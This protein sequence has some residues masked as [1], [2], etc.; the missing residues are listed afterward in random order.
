MLRPTALTSAN[1][2]ILGTRS[3]FS[4]HA[5]CPTAGCSV[6]CLAAVR[7]E[8]LIACTRCECSLC[9]ACAA[10]AT[11]WRSPTGQLLESLVTNTEPRFNFAFSPFDDDMRRMQQHSVVEPTLTAAWHEA[12]WKCCS[13]ADGIVVDVGGNFGWYTLFSLALGCSV[14]VFEPVPTFHEA[15]RLGLSLNPGFALRTKLYENVVYDAPGQYTLRVPKQAGR[16]RKKLGMTSMSGS[17]GYLKTN[18][19]SLTYLHNASSVRID[20]VV[21][22]SSRVCMLKADVEGYEPQVMQTAQRLLRTRKVA[23]VQ[24]E[25]TKTPSSREQTCATV[26]MLQMLHSLYAL[27]QVACGAASPTHT[28]KIE[29]KAPARLLT[30]ARLRPHHAHAKVREHTF[31]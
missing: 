21:P 5:A 10:T 25:L 26:K 6:D 8:P 30:H 20:D 24:L 22:L 29:I 17:A 16:R 14:I 15:L 18:W 12:T 11:R 7:K 31:T 4:K 27:K 13:E 19:K 28:Q 3:H 1:W 2:T 9:A 23:N